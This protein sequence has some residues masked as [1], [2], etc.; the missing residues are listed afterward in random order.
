MPPVREDLE[1]RL[2]AFGAP[3]TALMS[4]RT[5]P[6]PGH[7]RYLD[8]MSD[9]RKVRPDAV[10]EVDTEPLAYVAS[11]PQSTPDLAL[12]RRSLVCRADAPYLVVVRPGKLEIHSL[13]LEE[14]YDKR[15]KPRTILEHDKDAGSTFERLFLGVQKTGE[16][17]PNAV[18]SRLSALI[19]STIKDLA[20]AGLQVDDAISLAG[21]AMFSRFLIDREII[22]PRH[23]SQ[24]LHRG[25]TPSDFFSSPDNADKTCRWL[26]RIFNGDLLPFSFGDRLSGFAQIAPS[27]FRC[28]QQMMRCEESAQ[29]SFTWESLN[30]AHIPAGL[31]SQVYE[32]Q[33]AEWRGSER[34]KNSVYYTPRRIAEF[35]VGEAF[36]Q[37]RELFPV[38]DARV[39]DPAVGGGVFLVAAF[40][41]LVA[42]RWRARGSQPNT[43][44]IREILYGQLVGLDISETALRLTALSLYL[45]ALEL[46]P[47][48]RPPGRLKFKDSLRGRVL[49]DVSARPEGSLREIPQHIQAY[50]IVIG[51]PPWTAVERSRMA[52]IEVS[53]REFAGQRV[54]LPD[55]VPDIPFLWAATRWARTGGVIAFVL[56]ARWL[57]RQTDNGI[58]SRNEIFQSLDIL[59]VL[60][61]AEVRNTAV[62]ENVE[63]PFSIVFAV[64]RRPEPD[65]L[66]Y[67]VSPH[68]DKAL[69]RQGRLRVDAHASQPISVAKVVECPTILK[70]L[71]RGSALDLDVFEGLRA[72]FGASMVSI[73]QYW[74]KRHRGQG[75][76]KTAGGAD[77]AKHLFGKPD[78]RNDDF[79]HTIV[80][81]KSLDPYDRKKLGDTLERARQPEIYE[82][83]LVLLRKSPPSPSTGKRFATVAFASIAYG[84]SIS[85]WSCAWH[86]HPRGLAEYMYIIFNSDLFL[87]HVLMTSSEFGVEREVVQ[88]QDANEL[89][90]RPYEDIRM[91]FGRQISSAFHVAS[92]DWTKAHAVINDVINS[93]YGLDQWEARTIR[94]TLDTRSPYSSSVQRSQAPP[95]RD[96]EREFIALVADGITAVKGARPEI[97][98]VASPGRPWATLRIA[99]SK[100]P[101]RHSG[102]KRRIARAE[103]YGS[104]AVFSFDKH[105]LQVDILHQ[106]RYWTSTQAR[107]LVL[108][109]ISE[110]IDEL[111]AISPRDQTD[112]CPRLSYCLAAHK[113]VAGGARLGAIGPRRG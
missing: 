14:L 17:H 100:E 42:A 8:L 37:A 7:V 92:K 59:G 23:Y 111:R 6:T 10:I 89:L 68:I 108:E 84:E 73:A 11:E 90:I 45:A 61:C 5:T 57:F 35:M 32:Y 74:P 107:L 25:A 78:L 24:F 91:E 46:D 97:D 29:L 52:Q 51:N 86:P 82:A 87:W 70:T 85:G 9:A 43:E 69:N 26:D 83:P 13:G 54:T 39:L 31:L 3:P 48:P 105:S 112:H 44:E 19:N 21:R 2:S 65:G 104:S 94:D 81:V 95:S 28:L 101:M 18:A 4:L 33:A 49:H 77:D 55:T 38:A 41:E 64:N 12:L 53:V 58:E 71:F 15:S 98:L 79:Y 110:H 109:I 16:Y 22:T 67:Y 88:V 60:N 66:F 75:Y 62:W 106:R 102:D 63:Q 80:D 113:K 36:A 47:D 96:E 56:H 93:I 99:T 30:F 76:K 103:T 72:R 27:G 40:R 34:E 20:T 1:E 50:D